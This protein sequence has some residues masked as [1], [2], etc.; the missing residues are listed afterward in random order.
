MRQSAPDESVDG[1][2]L[3][4]I[5]TARKSDFTGARGGAGMFRPEML[6]ALGVKVP[7]LA[8]GLG[9]D[10]LAMIKLGLKDIRDLFTQ[11]L[12]MLRK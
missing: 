9:I 12:A 1:A 4:G 11:D 2:R 6:A 3:A 7:V 10:R 8:W 5:R